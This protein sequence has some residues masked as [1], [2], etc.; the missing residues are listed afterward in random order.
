LL[1]FD[2]HKGVHHRVRGQ[3]M[4]CCERGSER[5]GEGRQREESD[6]TAAHAIPLESVAAAGNSV[7]SRHNWVKVS[8]LGADRAYGTLTSFWMRRPVIVSAT[9]SEERRVGKECRSRW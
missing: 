1:G 9:R 6:P 3:V 7:P 8:G 4:G 5:D 2:L